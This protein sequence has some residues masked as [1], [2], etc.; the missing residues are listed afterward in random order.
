V[1]LGK[2][3]ERLQAAGIETLGIVASQAERA[4]LFFRYR[5]VRYAVGADPEVSTHR[6]YGVPQTGVTPEVM[7][8][9]HGAYRNLSRELKL[10]VPDDQAQEV[11]GRLDGFEPTESENAEFQRHQV[12][13]TGQFLVDRHGVV[14][15]ASI[16]CA[17][18]GLAGIDKFPTDEELLAAARVLS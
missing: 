18:D 7:Q 1:L 3:A 15:W 4:R 17:Q 5:P 10:E 12:Q 8:A 13:F 6:T 9:I 16:E 2:T 11:I 14:R